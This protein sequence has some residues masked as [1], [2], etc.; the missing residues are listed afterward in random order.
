MPKSLSA[1]I[2]VDLYPRTSFG[3][4]G[5]FQSWHDGELNSFLMEITAKILLKMDP[6]T[7]KTLVVH[8]NAAVS[9][10][11]HEGSQPGTAPGEAYMKTVTTAGQEDQ[12]SRIAAIQ[13]KLHHYAIAEQRV[14]AKR[15]A[16]IGQP[17][18]R[19]VIQS[20]PNEIVHRGERRALPR[21]TEQQSRE[22]ASADSAAGAQDAAVE[23]AGSA[24]RFLST[25]AAGD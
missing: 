20:A 23:S 18:L 17:H 22:F 6:K 19:S 3:L 13:R 1:R 9:G 4:A 15:R 8:T 25:H 11:P 14:A 12:F 2:V 7:N 5:L 10:F 16:K 24:Q 21:H